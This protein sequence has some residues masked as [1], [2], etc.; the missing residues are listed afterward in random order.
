[1]GVSNR[2]K[3]TKI[4]VAVVIFSTSGIGRR[5]IVSGTS[6]SGKG[7]GLALLEATEGR[8][9]EPSCHEQRRD[10]RQDEL[11]LTVQMF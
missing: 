5:W 11:L 9:Q 4:I 8:E 3:S 6:L 2:P 7:A 10:K 1:M